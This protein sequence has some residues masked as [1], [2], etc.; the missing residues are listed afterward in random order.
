MQITICFIF[1][2]HSLNKIPLTSWWNT[3]VKAISS[4]IHLRNAFHHRARNLYSGTDGKYRAYLSKLW[5]SY[6]RHN[7]HQGLYLPLF[8]LLMFYDLIFPYITLKPISPSVEVVE[9]TTALWDS[10]S[11]TYG[12]LILSIYHR[13]QAV[14]LYFH[15]SFFFKIA[16]LTSALEMNPTW[17]HMCLCYY[18]KRH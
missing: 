14:I 5:I 18:C 10:Q 2:I 11:L 13:P 9:K 8:P 3:V 17:T 6:S 4:S 1:C 16:F 7:L 15:S 12:H